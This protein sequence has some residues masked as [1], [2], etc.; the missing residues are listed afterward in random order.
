MKK[1][2]LAFILAFFS[3]SS[4]SAE[5]IN[6]IYGATLKDY[7]EFK[8]KNIATQRYYYGAD[9]E[10]NFFDFYV[11]K[12][13]D[14]KKPAIAVIHGGCWDSKFEGFQQAGEV[15]D[16]F[17]KNGY[18]VFNVEYTKADTSG[19]Y[20][21]T[22]SDISNALIKI[23]EVLNDKQITESGITLIGHSAGGHLASWAASG[24]EE[25]HSKNYLSKVKINQ[26]IGLG[27]IVDLKVAETACPNIIRFG[28]IDKISGKKMESTSPILMRNN[29][30]ITLINGGEDNIAPGK[31]AE[32][33]AKTH[34]DNVIISMIPEATHYDLMSSKSGV[35]NV[36]LNVLNED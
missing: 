21:T 1:I 9:K 5:V 4:T 23:T 11:P 10:N 7:M 34:K 16:F 24:G 30:R 35:L 15:V 22:Y 26:A 18:A 19:G 12:G 31:Y 13:L 6:P 2:K 28:G 8:P 3:I 20:P 25:T 36:V 17:L 27:A 33:Y 29:F 32:D 14:K